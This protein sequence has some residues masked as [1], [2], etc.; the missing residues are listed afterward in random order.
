ME[1]EEE[2]KEEPKEE[3]K[4]EEKPEEKKS[5]EPKEV[6]DKKIDLTKMIRKNP[7]V[8]STFVLG[9]VVLILLS[10]NLSGGMSGNVVSSTDAGN[11]LIAYLN[12]VTDSEVTLIDVEDEGSMYLATIEFKGEDMPIYVTKDGS[13]YAPSLVPLKISNSQSSSNNQEK[14]DIPKSD[15]PQVELFIW[16]Y[17]P[18]GV[19]AQGPLAE[20]ATLIGS[21][22]D[23]KAVL[24]HDGHGEYETQQNKIQACI[25]E[26]DK[27]NYWEYAT[28]FVDTIYPK[29]GSS[30][31]IECDK[32]ESISLM[33]SLGID[34]SAVMNCVDSDG[35]DLIDADSQRAKEVGV[36]GSPSLVI[37]DIK[38]NVA[39]TSE[40][41]KTAICEA[42]NEAPEECSTTLDSN[43]ATT[44][45]NC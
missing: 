14:Q 18:Y 37:N 34:S 31:D 41:Y 26:V 5:E 6:H 29:C 22:A 20:V 27:N 4:K 2:H 45:G 33:K 1:H 10:I 19:Q 32:T 25:Q 43:A 30:K 11:N 13:Y 38:V 23:I 28:G 40:A 24:Y 39:R 15:K 3:P 16:S 8:L 44:Q 36:T 7:W 21:D 17:C 35:Q 42:F 9:L 12:K